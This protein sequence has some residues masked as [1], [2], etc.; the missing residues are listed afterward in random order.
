MGLAPFHPFGEIHGHVVNREPLARVFLECSDLRV[1][2]NHLKR[3]L[4]AIRIGQKPWLFY[5]MKLVA[6]YAGIIC[7]QINSC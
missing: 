6:W 1:D 2:A 3:V 4:H 5:F 7:N